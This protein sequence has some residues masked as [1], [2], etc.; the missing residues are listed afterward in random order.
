MRAASTIDQGRRRFLFAR[1]QTEPAPFRPPWTDETL[2]D[3]RCTGC[4][5]CLR[6]CPENVLKPGAGGYPVF[7]PFAGSRECT[8]CGEC[9]AACN[10]DV[11]VTFRDPPWNIAAVLNEETCL[12]H[13][14]IHC[15]SCRD[16]CAEQAIRFRPRI[17]GPPTPTL[18]EAV[19]TG[20]GACIS[21]CPANALSLKHKEDA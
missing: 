8:F 9:A 5:D 21:S 15:E 2:L 16:V 4:G 12:A 1:K 20:C 7:D 13:R 10:E 18:E 14:D 6:A 19:C 3:S 11:F 17:G